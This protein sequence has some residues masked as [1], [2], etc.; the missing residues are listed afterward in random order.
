MLIPIAALKVVLLVLRM[1]FSTVHSRKTIIYPKADKRS[2]IP[3]VILK[4][5]QESIEN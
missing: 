5:L 3:R 4:L 2:C 1:S